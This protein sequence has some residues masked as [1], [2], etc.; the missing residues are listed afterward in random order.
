MKAICK[1]NKQNEQKEREKKDLPVD[2]SVRFA[3]PSGDDKTV[4][5]MHFTVQI[6][7]HF[8]GF[9]LSKKIILFFYKYLKKLLKRNIF[10]I[11]NIINSIRKEK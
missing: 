4:L 6:F 7:L 9:F 2:K 3:I 10:I 5:E 1:K 8:P 11:I